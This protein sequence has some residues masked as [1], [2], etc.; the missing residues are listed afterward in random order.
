MQCNKKE[1]SHKV[2]HMRETKSYN[3]SGDFVVTELGGGVR[4]RWDWVVNK[5]LCIYLAS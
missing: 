3:M 4:F 2:Y 1:N 5:V